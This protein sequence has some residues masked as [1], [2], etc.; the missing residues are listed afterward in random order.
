MEYKVTTSFVDLQDGNHEYGKGDAYPRDGASTSE[1]RI[2]ELSGSDNKRKTP[3]I[4]EVKT[5]ISP[6]EE[7]VK[8]QKA[9]KEKG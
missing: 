5:E 9:V 3:L 1:A 8:H 6:T 7:N 4:A 2:K